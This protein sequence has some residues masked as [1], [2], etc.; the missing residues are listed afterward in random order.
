MSIVSVK[1]TKT[2]IFKYYNREE[3][4]TH[5]VRM[6]EDGWRLIG[7]VEPLTFAYDKVL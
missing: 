2:Y 3:F 6:E 1:T 7:E 4:D 5:R